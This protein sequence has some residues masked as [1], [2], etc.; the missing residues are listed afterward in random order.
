MKLI[1][2]LIE[3]EILSLI[4][5]FPAIVLVGPRQVGKT[6][7]V[8][9]LDKKLKKPIEYIDLEN[10]EAMNQL[11]NP[12]LF[13]DSLKNKL[14]ILDEIQREPELFP[15]LRSL[16]DMFRKPG[17]FILLGS[18]SPE[19]I[20]DTSESLAGRVAYLEMHPLFL[21]EL[22]AIFD[23]KKLWIRGGFPNALFAK[24]DTQ[25]LIWREHF[26]RSYLE[27]DLPLLGLKTDPILI[28]R[29]WTMLA[30]LHGQLLNLSTIAN[31]LDISVPTVRRYI[32]FLESAF[33]VR[34]IH[35][36]YKNSGKRLI[37]SPKIYIRDSGILHALL[38]IETWYALQSHPSLGFSWESFVIQQ[39][40]GLLPPRCEIH[41]YRTQD[42]TEADLVIS[43]SGIPE[44]LVEIKYSVTPKPTKGFF[45][46]QKDLETKYH[47]IVCPI[48]KSYPLNEN[49]EII[50]I[51]D[52]NKIAAML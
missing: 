19:L 18:A 29:L 8:K 46:A 12:V 6:S 48:K 9:G 37:K 7:L 22:P 45:I 16:I 52:L 49:T 30:H 14:V 35:P 13:L 23:Y 47:F 2:R 40:V 5:H 24:N 3:K 41:F 31:S 27:R 44:L 21:N 1:P 36:W 50:S 20:R 39:I 51:Q 28:R 42:G 33:L 15:T 34:R 4:V 26:I 32:D 10:P 17:R 43:K 25:S 38:R 11:S